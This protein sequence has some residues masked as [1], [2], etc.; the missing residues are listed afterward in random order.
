M[1]GDCCSHSYFYDFI[2]VD[3]LL[4]NGP[5]VSAREVELKESDPRGVVPEHEH[6]YEYESIK[7]YGYEIVTEDPNFGPVTTVF[8]FRNSSNGYYGGELESCSEAPVGLKQITK[9]VLSPDDL[10]QVIIEI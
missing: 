5:V 7:V 4:N 6:E 3:K 8:S 1:Y 9:D 2:G 10:E